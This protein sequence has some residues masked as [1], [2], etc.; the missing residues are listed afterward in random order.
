M[1]ASMTSLT[2]CSRN[3]YCARSQMELAIIVA[4]HRGYRVLF[5]GAKSTLAREALVALDAAG[6]GIELDD[7]GTGYASLTHLRSIP[8]SRLKIDRWFFHPKHRG[9]RKQP[10]H[11]A[12]RHRLGPPLGCEIIAEGVEGEEQ[13]QV[14]RLMACDA[15][16]G[17]LFGRPMAEDQARLLLSAPPAT[18]VGLLRALAAK[19]QRRPPAKLCLVTRQSGTPHCTK[20]RQSPMN[21]LEAR[22]SRD[23]RST[24]ANIT[25]KRSIV[26]SGAAGRDRFGC[27]VGMTSC[28]QE[29]GFSDA[30][31]HIIPETYSSE[32]RG[33]KMP[34]P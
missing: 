30:I 19:M 12:G 5:P 4:H 23:G 9:G 21:G 27:G 25:A 15:A 8:V 22:H 11:R 10:R 31:R 32:R 16:Q 24:R 20:C 26:A 13:A 7:F 6:V 29:L 33:S 14:L 28:R 17:F 34:I 3:V 1:S 18:Q 2:G